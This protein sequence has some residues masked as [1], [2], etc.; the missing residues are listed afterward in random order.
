M[1]VIKIV[2]E[3]SVNKKTILEKKPERIL[4]Y[5]PL[6]IKP[7]SKSFFAISGN[8]EKIWKNCNLLIT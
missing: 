7:T 8:V 5:L 4:L 3:K 2:T 6:G 1:Y